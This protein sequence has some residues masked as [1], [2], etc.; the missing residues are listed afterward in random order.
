MLRCQIPG[1]HK[2]DLTV[3]QPLT[4]SFPVDN[5]KLAPRDG[6]PIRIGRHQAAIQ[7]DGQ[8]VT[9]DEVARFVSYQDATIPKRHQA[10]TCDLYADLAEGGGGHGGGVVILELR[11]E[12]PAWRAAG[13]ATPKIGRCDGLAVGDLV[14][15]TDR[16]RPPLSLRNRATSLGRHRTGRQ[17]DE[18]QAGRKNRTPHGSN[19]TRQG[20]GSLCPGRMNSEQ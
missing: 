15:A 19:G 17:G 4:P 10:P 5:L 9:T 6:F 14:E 16:V 2:G 18:R 12:Q 11:N 7:V 3:R 13:R 20:G 8:H 1:K